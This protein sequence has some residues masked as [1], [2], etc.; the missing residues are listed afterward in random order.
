MM[1]VNFFPTDFV[2]VSLGCHNKIL[3]TVLVKQQILIFSQFGG[4][5]VLYQSDSMVGFCY[6]LESSLSGHLLTLSSHGGEREAGEKVR[7]F[8]EGNKLSGVSFYK[9]TNT[10]MRASPMTS[11]NPNYPTKAPSPN[12]IIMGLRLHHM[13]VGKTQISNPQQTHHP[14][15]IFSIPTSKEISSRQQNVNCS[16]R[17][18]SMCHKM[19]PFKDMFLVV[20]IIFKFQFVGTWKQKKKVGCISIKSL[21]SLKNN[22]D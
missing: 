4:L 12:T 18:S 17:G 3:Q 9:D 10:I 20:V 5:E 11:T 6:K 14:I 2:V 19:L 15:Y 7:G 22:T 1:S 8:G 21:I 13:N 16:Y